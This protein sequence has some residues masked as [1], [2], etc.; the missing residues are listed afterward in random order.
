MWYHLAILFSIIIVPL[1][2][3]L[4]KALGIGVV[5]YIGIN[6]ILEQA[7]NYIQSQLGQ[8]TVLM[9]QML[10]VAKIDIAINLYLAAITTRAVLAGM[11]KVSGRKKDFVL[12][13]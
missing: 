6:L 9:Q 10:G 11:N 5:S 7:A 1:I 2:Q 4:L 3:K 12:K 13:A 8:T